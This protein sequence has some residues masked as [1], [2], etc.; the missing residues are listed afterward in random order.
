MCVSF[1]K[2]REASSGCGHA[3]SR[4]RSDGMGWDGMLLRQRGFVGMRLIDRRAPND[5]M[6]L[7]S[8]TRG[9]LEMRT[10]ILFFKLSAFNT[11]KHFPSRN[12]RVD[13]FNRRLFHQNH[14]KKL[15]SFETWKTQNLRSPIHYHRFSCCCFAL[16]PT[17][18]HSV[19]SSVLYSKILV[20]LPAQLCLF[21]Y[22]YKCLQ[23]IKFNVQNQNACA[24]PR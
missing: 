1:F 4:F 21:H 8:N 20:L 12:F 15:N 17:I 18:S 10:G 6:P 7:K 3:V 2:C 19:H 22:P 16:S 24:P 13:H 23:K 11:F 5:V 9:L 14:T